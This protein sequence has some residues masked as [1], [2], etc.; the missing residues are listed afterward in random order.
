MS[1]NKTDTAPETE[2]ERRAFEA[3]VGRLLD[4]VANALYSEREIFLREL[5]SNAADACDRLRYEAIAAPALLADDPELEIRVRIDKQAGT[6]TLSDN[7]VGMSRDELIANL[8]TIARSGS[9]A[10]LDRLTGDAKKDVTLIGQFGVGFYSAFMVAREVEVVSRR[11]GAREAWSWT[12]DGRGDY[13]LAPAARAG[14]GTDIRLTLKD[15]AEEFLDEARIRR[16]VKT[17]SDHIPVPITLAGAGEEGKDEQLNAAA[18]LWTRPKSE[19]EPDQYKEFYH[20]AAHAFDEPWATLH[21]KAEGVIEYTGLLFIPTMRPMD[22]FDPERKARVKLYV[23]RVFITD[24]CEAL[25]PPWLRFLRGVIDSED[26]PLNISREMLQG[27]PVLAKIKAG[28][29]KRVLSELEKKAKAEDEAD[30]YAAFWEAFGPVVKEGLYE[31]AGQRE[32]ILALARFRSTASKGWVSLADYVARMPEGQEAIY[33]IAGE[34]IE[35]LKRSPQLEGFR[36]KGIEV[37]FMT[38]P[39]DEFWLPAVGDFDGTAFKSVT[40]G[41]ADLSGLKKADGGDADTAEDADDT[42]T[43]DDTRLATLIA[44]LKTALGEDVADVRKSDRLTDSAVCLV[45]ADGGLDLN[46]ER[47]L[48]RHNQMDMVSKRVLEINP[49]HDLIKALAERPVDADVSDA[50]HLLLDQAR[51]LE[52]EALP[53]PAAFARRMTAVMRQGL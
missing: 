35:V 19:I 28:V 43:A 10:F 37:L 45:A 53:D 41:A 12:S 48:K 22:L 27:S 2:P 47:L 23:K 13:A 25:L 3:E 36:A 5:I 42:D 32:A 1:E 14:R 18:A 34:D 6:L 49:G 50:A 24:D 51:I 26:L 46:M 11:A 39:V 15:D 4:I 33:Y 9:G 7:G 30:G 21:F 44:K 38:D 16:I 52:G 20:H 8:G 40:R 17:Y 29:T 31:D